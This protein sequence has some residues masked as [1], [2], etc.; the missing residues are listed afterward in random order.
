[1]QRISNPITALT[2]SCL[3]GMFSPAF[4]QDEATPEPSPMEQAGALYA[5]GDWVGAAKIYR[6]VTEAEPNNGAAFFGLGRSLYDSRQVD[7]ALAAFEKA[8]QLG[9]QPGLTVLYLARGH[10]AK[11]DDEKALDWL[12]KAAQV[13]PSIYQSIITTEEFRR[14]QDNETFQ[15]IVA[16]VKPCNSPA[17]HL[18]DF[19]VGSWDVSSADGSQKAGKNTIAKILDGCAIIENW[20]GVSGSEGKSLFYFSDTEQTW[21]QVWMTDSQAI[22]EKHMIARADSGALRFQ[23]EVRQGD[24]SRL[25]DRT[26]LS[27]L[28]ENRVHQLIEQSR[29]GGETWQPTFSAVY[30]RVGS[31]G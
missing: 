6:S 11:G 1:M 23:G 10:A 21:K 3:L 31:D 4:A 17:Y 13:G 28:D 12:A 16:A 27:P 19:W 18:L 24:G 29:D 9:F 25:L 14:F 20:V 7:P 30:T 2:L 5:K 8:G 22:K 15:A 26:T